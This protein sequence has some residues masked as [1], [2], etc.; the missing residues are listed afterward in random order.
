MIVLISAIV[1]RNLDRCHFRCMIV[2]KKACESRIACQY[3]QGKLAAQL[4]RY[5]RHVEFTYNPEYGD[6][7]AE[8]HGHAVAT[9]LPISAEPIV[10]PG[11]SVPTYFAGLLPEGRRLTALRTHLKTSTDDDFTMLLAVGADP[12]GDVQVVPRGEPCPAF[13]DPAHDS[14]ARGRPSLADIS[15]RDLFAATIGGSP[16]SHGVAGLQDKVSGR[17]ISVPINVS[18]GSAHILKLDPPEFPHLVRNE[19]FFLTM[20]AE[21]RLRT[22]KWTLVKDRD[23]RDGLLV[24]RFDRLAGSN[25]SVLALACE[26][27]CQF[28]NRYPADKY[29]LDTES[30]I[31]TASAL[32]AA[33]AVGAVTLLRQ[34]AFAIVTGNGDLHAKNMSLLRVNGEWRVS[35]SYDL[36]SSAP[37]G[38]RTL[39]VP[40]KG[41]TNGQISRRRFLALAATLGV[42][43]RAAV[44]MLDEL[45]AN[46]QPWIDRL[47]ELPF[48]QR[49]IRDLRRLMI[50]RHKLLASP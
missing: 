3:V 13:G 16:D 20:A 6:K 9:T 44:A 27:G 21:C 43:E 39:A 35:P 28:S 25:G 48:D 50:Q 5:D 8:H 7:R 23:G 38:D 36:P 15:F 45:L 33:R 2:H 4:R 19:A 22:A 30:L 1:P 46:V 42:Y 10:T 37:Y 14:G 18:N 34:L 11:R 12:I 49:L 41:R 31:S 32:C 40:I 24:E 29:A 47:H 26:D 17:M